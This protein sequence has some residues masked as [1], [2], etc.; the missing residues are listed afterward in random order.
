MTVGLG[1]ATIVHFIATGSGWRVGA[2]RTGRLLRL[3]AQRHELA[4]PPVA[5]SSS[6][7]MTPDWRVLLI[8]TLVGLPMLAVVSSWPVAALLSLLAVVVRIVVQRMHTARQRS[9][10][11]ASARDLA[12]ALA[13]ALAAGQSVRT[14]VTSA[15][16]TLDGP[17]QPHLLKAARELHLGSELDS[18]LS[19]FAANTQSPRIGVLIGALNLQRRSG[20]DLAGLLYELAA[21]FRQR[22]HSQ[23]DARTATAQARMTAWI[24]IGAPLAVAVLAEL[25][26]RGALTGVFEVAPAAILLGV[27]CLLYL[28]GALWVM[29]LARVG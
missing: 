26:H 22:D 15:A 27:S 29:R 4:V 10:L 2:K 7:V 14:A 8:A 16:K 11:D 21:A 24:V 25:L 17:L 6:G 13:A 12:L 5:A 18:V 20:G 19:A 3:L 9:A 28:A 23:R 1:V